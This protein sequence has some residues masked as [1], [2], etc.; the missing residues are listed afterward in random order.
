MAQPTTVHLADVKK[1]LK[2]VKGT[3]NHGIHI[4]KTNMFIQAFADTDWVGNLDDRRSTT[5]NV[6]YLGTNPISWLAKKQPTV[7]KL[8]TEAEYGA[9]SFV[10]AELTWIAHRVRD[11]KLQNLPT[12][13][14]WQDN[15][16]AI[17]LTSNPV[18]HQW[19]KHFDINYR[20]IKELGLSKALHIYHIL[21]VNQVA[22]ILTKGLP[23]H[24]FLQ[25]HNKILVITNRPS[26]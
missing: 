26:A 3:M 20:N 17:T 5:S 18:S 7:A 24:K 25:L 4:T 1:I 23:K 19:S 10:A 22:D 14:P 16:S 15:Q 8:S 6:V 21:I 12:P 13:T 11:L 2:N 9:R